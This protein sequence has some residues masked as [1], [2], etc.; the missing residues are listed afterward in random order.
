MLKTVKAGLLGAAAVGLATSA[1]A[2]EIDAQNYSVGVNITVEEEVSLWSVDDNVSLVLNG[3]NDENSDT[4]ESGIYVLTN[5]DANVSAKVE[6]ADPDALAAQAQFYIFNGTEAGLQAAIA[7]TVGPVASGAK[8][9]TQGTLNTSQVVIPSTG[10][11]STP[12]LV[13][14]AYGAG[15]PLELP[16]PDAYDLTVTWTIAENP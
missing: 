16:P 15:A 9:W 13:T 5:T 8:M 4:V 11:Q 12:D 7:S 6:S 14:V 1:M 2:G 3:A 10:L